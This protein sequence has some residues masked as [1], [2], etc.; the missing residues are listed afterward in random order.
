MPNV[1]VVDAA[2][3]AVVERRIRSSRTKLREWTQEAIERMNEDGAFDRPLLWYYSPMDSSLV[4]GPLR[5]P[6]RRLRLHGRALAVHRRAQ[7]SWSTTKRRLIEHADVVFTGGYNLGEKKKKQHDN[8][9]I[10]GCGVEFYALQQG[11]G[12]EH[13]HPAGHRLHGP[14]DPRLVR[15]GR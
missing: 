10:F 5:E 2:L 15:R 8:V 11:A 12:P 6:R 14:P 9:H 4:A 7:G 3:L 1:T 13:A